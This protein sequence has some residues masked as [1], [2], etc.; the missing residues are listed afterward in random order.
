MERLS[1]A[2]DTA[3]SPTEAS[4]HVGRYAPVLPFCR[5]KRVLD[6]ACGEG[7]GSW[8]ISQ[9]GA[10]AVKGVDISGE[11]IAEAKRSF[12]AD[13]LSYRRCD[14]QK[15]SASLR[16]ARF[17]VIVCIETIEH[18]GD[19]KAFLRELRNLAK[20]DCL[21]LITCP[22]DHWYYDADQSNP[23]HVRKYTFAE[24]QELTTAELGQNVRWFTGT[25]AQGFATVPM[26]ANGGEGG[27]SPTRY[28]AVDRLGSVLLCQSR[29]EDR[30]DDSTCSYFVG[31][32]NAPDD[33]FGGGAF[34]PMSMAEYAT[35]ESAA[36]SI[37]Q[38]RAARTDAIR[39][40]EEVQDVKDAEIADLKKQ[41]AALST[42]LTELQTRFRFDLDARDIELRTLREAKEGEIAGLRAQIEAFDAA[43]ASLEGRLEV[44]GT[45]VAGLHEQ[46]AA[47][48]S[49]ASKHADDL[50]AH[51]VQAA[52]LRRENDILAES[53]KRLKDE[54]DA[55]GREQAQHLAA[56][57]EGKAAEI[58]QIRQIKD[59]EIASLREALS[60]ESARAA[61]F[62][63]ELDQVRVNRDRLAAENAVMDA[64]LS[65]WRARKAKLVGL[66]PKALKPPIS[67]AYRLVAK[68]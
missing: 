34:F 54:R 10:S 49:Q 38:L 44:R 19:P 48:T 21:I 51:R 29:G 12:Q 35:R 30:V 5:G 2:Q 28:V 53:V 67:W 13:N 58:R 66:V 18:I 42:S 37:P 57:D 56:P 11:A 20:E 1:I 40:L 47:L 14:A 61:Q 31:V 4:I 33:T 41:N 22:N 45:E 63:S 59:N 25:A 60:N 46:L 27:P 9:A 15:L 68:R 39:R 65:F 43:R 3:Y 52:A 24:F 23:Y 55:A 36:E 16:E 64:S 6:V 50:R 17:D 62:H 32:W 7:Y 26:A 8:L